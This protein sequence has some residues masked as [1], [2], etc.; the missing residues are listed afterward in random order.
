MTIL[1]G[2][3]KASSAVRLNSGNS[4]RKSTPWCASDTS[5]GREVATTPA[6]PEVDTGGGGCLNGLRVTSVPL[7]H[8]ARAVDLGHLD[9]LLHGERRRMPRHPARQHGLPEPGG[10]LMMTL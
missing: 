10:P 6:S 3:R 5:P 9:A 1:Q 2:W 8:S 7:P 4:S